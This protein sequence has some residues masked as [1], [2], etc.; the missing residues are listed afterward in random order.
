MCRRR[1]MRNGN[2]LNEMST[3]GVVQSVKSQG[4][5]QG[6]RVQALS[7]PPPLKQKIMESHLKF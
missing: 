3:I 7:S 1:A 4:N 2:K 5:S 6:R